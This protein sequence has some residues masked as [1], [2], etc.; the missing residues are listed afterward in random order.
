MV[1]HVAASWE[2]PDNGIWEVRGGQRHY[3]Y[4]KL[5]SW[6]ALD[7]GLKLAELLELSRSRSDR[8]T[9]IR[10]QVRHAI[11]TR[12]WSEKLG[13]FRQAFDED[14]LDA[15]SLMIPMLNFLPAMDPRMRSTV[16]AIQSQLTDDNGFVYRYRHDDG[17]PGDE[18][19]FLLCSFWLVNNLC[20]QR[21]VGPARDLFERLTAHGNDLGLFSEELDPKTGQ[22]LGNFPQAFT[23][24][25]I[26]IAAA[27]IERADQNRGPLE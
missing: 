20:L 26:I 11:L 16:S 12:G 21:Q 14:S 22:M 25:A 8:W 23:H 15:T 2:Q 27:H 1:D 3:V 5:Q 7:R 19:T 4:S 9:R 24:L 10:E 18:G 6:V 17:L 13:A